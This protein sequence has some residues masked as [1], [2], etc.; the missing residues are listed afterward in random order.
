MGGAGSLFGNGIDVHA[1]AGGEEFGKEQERAWRQPRGIELGRDILVGGGLVF[2][3]D[4]DLEAG[5]VHTWICSRWRVGLEC[6]CG[7]GAAAAVRVA[8]R[9]ALN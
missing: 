3:H 5:D 1:E 6:F 9:L 8:S 4:G 2:P 7:G